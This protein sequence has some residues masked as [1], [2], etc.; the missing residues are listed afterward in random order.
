MVLLVAS[1]GGDLDGRGNVNV[2]VNVNENMNVSNG[3]RGVEIEGSCVGRT[4]VREAAGKFG[5]SSRVGG[6][7]CV[8]M[9]GS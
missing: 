3:E 8:C 5:E 2:N 4:W 7:G 9:Y 1:I 6:Q